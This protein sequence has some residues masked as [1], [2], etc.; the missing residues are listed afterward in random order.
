MAVG[1]HPA[2]GLKR[3]IGV[4]LQGLIKNLAQS[5]REAMGQLVAEAQDRGGNAVI[6]MRFDVSELGDALTEICAYGTAVQAVPVTE[7]AK[8][9]AQQLGYGSQSSATTL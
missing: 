6:A 9:T 1:T 7:G 4:E 2:L 8:Y 3:I 5:R